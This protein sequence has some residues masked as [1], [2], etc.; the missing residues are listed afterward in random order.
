MKGWDGLFERMERSVPVEV[1]FEMAERRVEKEDLRGTRGAVGISKWDSG[2]E[3]GIGAG[4]GALQ[5]V[6]GP[7]QMQALTTS[8]SA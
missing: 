7:I 8:S 1:F 2:A 6:L 5:S 3:I 4:A